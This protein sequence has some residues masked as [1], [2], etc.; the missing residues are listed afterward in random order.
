V[1]QFSASVN[2]VGKTVTIGTF[3]LSQFF[4]SVFKPL[5]NQVIGS[6]AAMQDLVYFPLSTVPFPA[7]TMLLYQHIIEI[8]VFDILP[9]DDWYPDWFDLPLTEP[10]SPEFERFDYD[11]SLFI[12][13]AGP[14]WIFGVLLI[15]KYPLFWFVK[16]SKYQLLGRIENNLRDELFWASPI[17]FMITGYVEFVFAALVN[18]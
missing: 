10:F 18:Y 9:T 6:M 13:S 5:M 16:N 8:V 7:T 2:T 11:S 15:L 1:V 4:S 12:E 3:V 17:D 14:M